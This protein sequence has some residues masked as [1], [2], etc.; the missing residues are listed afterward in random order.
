MNYKRYLLTFKEEQYIYFYKNNSNNSTEF[1]YWTCALLL[2][3]LKVYEKKHAKPIF[4]FVQ[5]LVSMIL[6][7]F[8][9][10]ETMKCKL[11]AQNQ[12]SSKVQIM[13]FYQDKT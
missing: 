10:I 3:Y 5:I 1:I 7:G 12:I 8:I 6:I 11:L 4:F 9:R 2:W 13:Y